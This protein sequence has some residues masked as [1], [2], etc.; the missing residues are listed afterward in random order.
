MSLPEENTEYA[1]LKVLAE[2]VA[3]RMAAIKAKH[4][5]RLLDVYAATGVNSYKVR[6]PDLGLVATVTVPIPEPKVVYDDAAQ[7]A[8]W[9]AANRPALV[10]QVV[11]PAVAAHVFYRLRPK[12]GE[13][14]AKV[15]QHAAGGLLVDPDTG[16]VV[17]GV[18]REIVEPTYIRASYPKAG[19]GQILDAYR[20]G[21]LDAA[22]ADALPELTRGVSR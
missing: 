9:C 3:E 15:C 12:A 22:M 11:V 13:A 10:E 21:D 6:L 2:A 14:L 19:R 20:A 7:L 18:H 4:T 5:A 17:P 16:E 8:A 1:V